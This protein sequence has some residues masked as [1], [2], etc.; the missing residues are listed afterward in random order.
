MQWWGAPFLALAFVAHERRAPRPNSTDDRRIL[1]R[2]ELAFA[3]KRSNSDGAACASRG[4]PPPAMLRV[5]RSAG[6]LREPRA[7]DSVL[8]LMRRPAIL[9]ATPFRFEDSVRIT[10]ISCIPLLVS[11]I[12]KVDFGPVPVNLNGKPL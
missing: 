3:M 11:R 8:R 5:T 10:D 2:H 12:G 7:A 4:A 1:P 6:A 9:C